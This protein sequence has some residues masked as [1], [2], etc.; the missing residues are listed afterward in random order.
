MPQNNTFGGWP[1]SGEIDIW[2]SV[3]QTQEAHGSLH[4]N[5]TYTLGK[6]GN[7]NKMSGIDYT[8]W[9]VYSVEWTDSKITWYVD[10]NKMWSYSKS[11]KQ[12][13]LDQL[14]WPFDYPFYLILNQS[15]GT[16]SWADSPD[17]NHTYETLFDWVRVYQYPSDVTGIT[18]LEGCDEATEGGTDMYDLTGRRVQDNFRGIAIVNGKKTVK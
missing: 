16:G 15:V 6:G 4:T 11:T 5:W 10:G 12:S 3:N 13:D 1:A 17:K 8:M 2:E 14:Q 9:H 18:N 7:T